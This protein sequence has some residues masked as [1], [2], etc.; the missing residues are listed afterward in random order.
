MSITQKSDNVELIAQR[1][2]RPDCARTS[3]LCIIALPETRFWDIP[4]L[5]LPGYVVCGSQSGLVTLLVSDRFLGSNDPGVPKRDVQLIYLDRYVMSVYAPD[6]KKELKVYEEFVEDAKRILWEGRRAGARS[7]YIA[8]DLNVELG[9][10]C[11]DDD[12]A[13]E[14]SEMYGPLCWQNYDTDPRGH[15]KMSWYEIMKEF[16]CRAS[17]TWSSCDDRKEM[18]LTQRDWGPE[19]RVFQLDCILCPRKASIQAYIHNDVKSWSTWDYYL[20]YAVK[21]EEDEQNFLPR[22]KGKGNKRICRLETKG[23]RGE[24]SSKKLR[25]AKKKKR[26]TRGWSGHDSNKYWRSG[27]ESCAHNEGRERKGGD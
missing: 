8:D 1:L 7:V 9:L 27:K 6:S 13:E 3:A 22:K 20:V 18:A 25:C 5:K 21:Q 10:L 14:I 11:T 17:S 16:D 24:N 12:D 26:W 2:L 19:G 15:K 4:Q 23:W